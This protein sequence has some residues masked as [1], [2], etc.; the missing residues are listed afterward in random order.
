MTHGDGGCFTYRAD[1]NNHHW[2]SWTFCPA[3]GATFALTAADDLDG[4]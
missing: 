4:A 2:R 1:L 3:S